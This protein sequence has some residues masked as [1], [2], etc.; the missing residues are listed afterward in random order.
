MKTRYAVYLVDSL[1]K[2]QL[3]KMIAHDLAHKDMAQKPIK[4]YL[5]GMDAGLK[6]RFVVL[7][8]IED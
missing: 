6:V 5:D 8:Y 4:E 1:E 3:G 7:E 2:G